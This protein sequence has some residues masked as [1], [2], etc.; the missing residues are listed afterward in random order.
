MGHVHFNG[1]PTPSSKHNITPVTDDY[2][3]THYRHKTSCSLP[4]PGL[5]L[6]IKQLAKKKR[7]GL[8]LRSNK[9]VA[10]PASPPLDLEATN[11]RTQTTSHRSN[12]S[13][14]SASPRPSGSPLDW[15]GLERTPLAGD[16]GGRMV[17]PPVFVDARRVRR[18]GRRDPPPPLPP[19]SRFRD[20]L[21]P[22]Q[23]G[24]VFQANP[25]RSEMSLAHTCQD[26]TSPMDVLWGVRWYFGATTPPPSATTRSPNRHHPG[27]PTTPYPY[28]PPR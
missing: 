15:N 18:R 11:C 26:L 24:C 2:I 3:T 6:L 16:G 19:P 8:R 7:G 4:P 27:I 13:P 20:R 12:F 10:F 28:H 25:F 21:V 9:A 17:C 1:E 22:N 5:R 23:W 14:W